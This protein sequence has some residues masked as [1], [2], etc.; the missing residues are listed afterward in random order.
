M[1]ACF[2]NFYIIFLLYAFTSLPIF[3]YEARKFQIQNGM[4]LRKAMKHCPDLICIPYEFENYRETSRLLYSIVARY[5]L[6]IKAISCDEL[7]VDL[8]DLCTQTGISDPMVIVEEI[9]KD[10]FEETGCTA[11]AGLGK[12]F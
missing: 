11:S 4:W 5:T 1:Q 2:Y 6:D 3:S 10:I 7:Y 8:T 12:V 9:R